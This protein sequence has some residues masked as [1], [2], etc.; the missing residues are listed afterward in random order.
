MQ[1]TKH[2][3]LTK[4]RQERHGWHGCPQI[5]NEKKIRPWESVGIGGVSW[6]MAV[7]AMLLLAGSAHAQLN[8]SGT[9]NAT[10][11]NKSGISIVFNSDASGVALSGSGTAAAGLNFGTVSMYGTAPA[12]VTVTRA[13]GSFTVSSPFDVFVDIGGT[14]SPSYRLQANLAAVPGVYSYQIDAVP[15]S[16]ALTTV[17]AADPNYRTNVLHT[18]YLTI[19]ASAPA[20]AVSNT[21]QFTVTAN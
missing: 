6:L 21:V 9:L 4:P 8:A 1:A 12:G 10:L 7:A 14:A 11:I 2:N 15:L 17:V 5:E 20:G 16:T 13:A 18:M 3:S 19:P